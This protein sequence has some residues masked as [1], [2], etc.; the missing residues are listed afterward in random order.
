MT[1]DARAI[2]HHALGQ[3]EIWEKIKHCMDTVDLL[4][5]VAERFQK[6]VTSGNRPFDWQEQEQAISDMSKEIALI[7]ASEVKRIQ[8]IAQSS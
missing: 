4:D 6:A 3:S 2:A 8:S 1:R 5:R 7:A